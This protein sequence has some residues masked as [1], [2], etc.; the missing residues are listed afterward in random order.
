MIEEMVQYCN[1]TILS[2][3]TFLYELTIGAV[4]A[5]LWSIRESA[6]HTTCEYLPESHWDDPVFAFLECGPRLR[7][8]KYA[9][10][11]AAPYI[12]ASGCLIVTI[13][14][15][16]L[17]RKRLWEETGLR[18][19]YFNLVARYS[20]NIE[21]GT[22]CEFVHNFQLT[23]QRPSTNH[24]HPDAALLRNSAARAIQQWIRNAGFV[25]YST[26]AGNR[27]K[28]AGTHGWF[29]A[30]DLAHLPRRLP[31]TKDHIIMSIDDDY[32]RNIAHDAIHERPIVLYT[33]DPLQV[34]GTMANAHYFVGENDTVIMRVNGGA[35]YQ[36][37]LWNW[38]VDTLVFDYYF[39][40][41]SLVFS[42][43]RRRV[44]DHHSIVLLTPMRRVSAPFGW[45][46]PGKRLTR[47]RMSHGKY[48]EVEYTTAT[49]ECY[50]SIG[51]VGRPGA[52]NLP[53]A[54]WEAIL[55]KAATDKITNTW[56]IQSYLSALKLNP[57]EATFA[58][59]TIRDYLKERRGVDVQVNTHSGTIGTPPPQYVVALKDSRAA[60]LAPSRETGTLIAKPLTT[61]PA[62]VPSVHHNN[63]LASIIGRLEKVTNTKTPPNRFTAYT[64]EFVNKALGSARGTV[65]PWTV[66][67]VLE[68]QDGPLQ[69]GR[70]DQVKDWLFFDR[71]IM[72]EAMMKKECTTNAG[73][74]RNI[75]TLPTPHNILLSRYTY[76]VKKAVLQ[77]LP[78][79]MPCRTPQ[80]VA[81]RLAQICAGRQLITEA[82][83]SRFDGRVSEWIMVNVQRHFYLGAV[84][85]DYRDELREAL[86][87]DMSRL[88]KTASG[89]R[90]DAG[91]GRKSGSPLTT[92]GNTLITAFIDYATHRETGLT[93][94]EA[95]SE[96]AAYAGDD[97]VSRAPADILAAT[98]AELGMVH[99]TISH[100]PGSPVGFLGRKFLGL[101]GGDTR[102]LQDPLRTYNKLHISFAP[103]HVPL[104]QRMADR[105]FGY[106]VLDP[107]H[108]LL[109]NWCSAILRVA[110]S[111]DS[112]VVGKISPADCPYYLWSNYGPHFNTWPQYDDEDEAYDALSAITNVPTDRLKEVAAALD[113]INTQEDLEAMPPLIDLPPAPAKNTVIATDDAFSVPPDM[114]LTPMPAKRAPAPVQHKKDTAEKKPVNARKQVRAANHRKSV[115]K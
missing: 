5:F 113:K 61:T 108:P 8:W 21:P 23:L 73:D 67:Q 76:A 28:N 16:I 59:S 107:G 51:L 103:K 18:E 115:A 92:D 97:I 50:T 100:G 96:L 62:T 57:D 64:Q 106:A 99:E 86:D 109:V 26:S 36:H 112:K 44:D 75:S 12:A 104:A 55:A 30:K 2:W 91:F 53:T 72:V 85:H 10:I 6:I 49:G 56:T 29:M 111:I 35:E 98:S 114:E 40:F 89:T 105:A 81:D 95:W 69:R 3:T 33:F 24:S 70:N 9:L 15:V 4:K 1:D 17:L 90:Y 19:A 25:P 48:S 39:R 94:D 79:Y 63:D 52:A 66:E 14:A 7:P 77:H 60:A 68:A 45:L 22:R 58:A 42:V 102:S 74:P 46:L 41:R 38:N 78:F 83:G 37:Q 93:A 82:D 13:S 110:R 101:H 88:A 34:A 43:E 84:H 32:Y 87:A 71:A 65:V 80:E 27:E 47:R 20:T 54:T 11:A 31:V